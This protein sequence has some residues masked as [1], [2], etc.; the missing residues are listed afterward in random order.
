MFCVVGVIN[1]QLLVICFSKRL[2]MAHVKTLEMT[3]DVLCVKFR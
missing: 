1:G 3:D 2:S